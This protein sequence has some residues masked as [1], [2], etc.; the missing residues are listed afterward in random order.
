MHHVLEEKL[1]RTSQKKFHMLN[2][3]FEKKRGFVCPN[4]I[5]SVPGYII[6]KLKIIYFAWLEKMPTTRDR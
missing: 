3:N 1:K 2:E 5:K 6:T 4:S